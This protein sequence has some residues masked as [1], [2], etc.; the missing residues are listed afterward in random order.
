M[1]IGMAWGPSFWTDV[2]GEGSLVAG[3]VQVKKGQTGLWHRCLGW[4]MGLGLIVYWLA[5]RVDDQK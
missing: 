5:W 1:C 4:L 2:L 3:A